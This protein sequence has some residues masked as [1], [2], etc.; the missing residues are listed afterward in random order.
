MISSDSRLPSK[1]NRLNFIDSLRKNKNYFE[2]RKEKQALEKDIIKEKRINKRKKKLNKVNICKICGE[3]GHLRFD[4]RNHFI[5]KKEKKQNLKKECKSL[6]EK[7]K[8]LQDKKKKLIKKKKN[9]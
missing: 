6:K 7:L 4:C 3:E 1:S 9:K 5:L 8:M 2:K